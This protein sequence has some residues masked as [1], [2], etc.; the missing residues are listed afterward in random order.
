MD[1]AATQSGSCLPDATWIAAQ[2]G[3]SATASDGVIGLGRSVVTSQMP[4]DCNLKN[5]ALANMTSDMTE[6]DLF[7]KFAPSTADQAQSTENDA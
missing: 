2:R 1:L 4:I 6:G 3:L 7:A 5:Y